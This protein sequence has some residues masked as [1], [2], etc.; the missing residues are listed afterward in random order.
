[1]QL[2][3]VAAGFTPGE[4]D[5]LRRVDGGVDGARAASRS[6][7]SG[8]STAWST[9]RLQPKRS[10][11]QHLPADP[12]LR[13]IRLSRKP[14]G[15][16]RAARLRLALAQA[17]PARRRSSAALL[18]SQPMG[19]YAPAQLVHDARAARRRGAAGRRHGQRAGTARS[20]DGWRRIRAPMRRAWRARSRAAPRPAPRQRALAR[21]ARERIV[22]RA[23]RGAVRRASPTSRAARELDAARPGRAR[24]RRCACGARRPSPPAR[25][26]TSPASTRVPPRCCARRALDEADAALPRADRRRGHR[27]RLPRAR[28]HAAAPS[29]GAAAPPSSRSGGCSTAADI[30]RTPHG[31]LARTAGIVIGRQ[32]PETASGVIFV[33]LEDETGAINVIVWRDLSRPPA[34]RAAR[35]APAGGA[36]ARSSARARSCT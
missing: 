9:T 27:R 35:R 13:R 8:W 2:A 3:I 24:R 6:S 26:G 23:R 31:R 20:R 10:R 4:A 11:E 17:P 33:T 29:A 16:L 18:N 21:P 15:A 32:R 5:Q 30:A 12:G 19:F 22:A 7:S 28:P 1:M 34:P 14:R 25:R 36:T